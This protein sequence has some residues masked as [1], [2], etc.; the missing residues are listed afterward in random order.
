MEKNPFYRIAEAGIAIVIAVM[1]AGGC[2]GGGMIPVFTMDEL[3]QMQADK[4]SENRIFVYENYEEGEE[5]VWD[6]TIYDYEKKS[7]NTIFTYTNSDWYNGVYGLDIESEAEKIAYGFGPY[8]MTELK[9]MN[10]DGT[11]NSTL[12]DGS[13]LDARPVFSPDGEKICFTST[14][15]Q[16]AN[17]VSVIGTDGTGLIQITNDQPANFHCAWSPDGTLLA[18]DQY[19]SPG[20][21]IIENADGSGNVHTSAADSN[22]YQE[23]R[24]SPDGD[25]VAFNV[26]P[27]MYNLSDITLYSIYVFDADDNYSGTMVCDSCYYFNT[28]WSAD[29]EEA[30]Y[31]DGSGTP[32]IKIID[33]D[34][35]Q[36]KETISFRQGD[37][38]VN[39]GVID[40]SADGRK[41]LLLDNKQ[42]SQ[43]SYEYA[44]YIYDRDT[45]TYTDVLDFKAYSDVYAEFLD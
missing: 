12:Y 19:D 38:A 28:F 39:A 25:R 6:F 29:G 44:I 27:D 3:V 1:F 24:W 23:P 40:W 4:E 33:A 43:Y 2:G 17:D 20:N 11:E 8:P 9:T 14:D 21:I 30:A 18:V 41:L 15:P 31:T 5:Y 13:G 32:S 45:E 42:I 37:R 22:H 16:V 34:T 35:F 7:V 26:K 36:V 10:L